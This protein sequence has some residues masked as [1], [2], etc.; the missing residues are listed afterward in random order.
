MA[1]H[2]RPSLSVQSIVALRYAAIVFI[3]VYKRPP[4]KN[5]DVIAYPLRN[6][7]LQI[8]SACAT[9]KKF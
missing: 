6:Q 9:P 7:L 5:G 2:Y 4:L 8:L 3:V 1:R